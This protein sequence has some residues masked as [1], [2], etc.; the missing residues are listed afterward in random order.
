MTHA[1]TQETAAHRRPAYAM[2]YSPPFLQLLGRRSA[3]HNASHLMPLLR[4][5]MTVL[6]LG[7][8]PGQ[9]TLGLAQAVYPGTVHGI[10]VEAHQVDLAYRNSN[11]QGVHNVIFTQED[12]SSLDLP[13]NHFD[14]IHCHAFLMHAPNTKAVLEEAHRVLKPGG[15]IAAREMD[16]PASYIA[17]SNPRGSSLW[18][19]L[20][21]VMSQAG[22]HPVMGR[23]LKTYFNNA[24]FAR[25]AAG[26][27]AD[28]FDTPEDITFLRDFLQGWALSDETILKTRD[29][30]YTQQDFRRWQ[31]Q[32]DRWS[33]H[34]GAVGCFQ[35]SHA[36]AIKP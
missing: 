24:G 31:D 6:D 13:G 21:D 29:L 17:P 4:P 30:P 22:G 5:G 10:D 27:T 14:A 36:T 26:A 32:V 12:A 20:A 7:S 9:I 33:R 1:A 18:Q 19:M 3:Q 35:F 11:T 25:V 15:I 28:F 8:G 16:V 23:Q 34:P 2:G